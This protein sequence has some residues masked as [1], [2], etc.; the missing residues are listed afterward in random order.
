MEQREYALY[1]RCL[2]WYCIDPDFRALMDESPRRAV[3]KLGYGQSLNGEQAYRA[4]RW[5]VF[6]EPWG[7]APDD[8][9][10]LQAV[11]ARE[12][13]LRS[14][15]MRCHSR[16]GF[17]SEHLYSYEQMTRNRCRMESRLVRRNDYV[18]YFPFCIELSKGCSVQCSF[19]GL[20]AEPHRGDFLYTEENRGLFR[21]VVQAAYRHFGSILG[22]CPLYFATEPF[23]NPDYER[24]MV[25]FRQITGLLPQTTTAIA[26]RDPQRLRRWME[27][28]GPQALQEHAAL[29]IS[30]RS[31]EQFHKIAALYSPEELASVELVANNPQ[32]IH[33]YSA[34]GRAMDAPYGSRTA[35][36]YSICCIS[37]IRVNLVE[38]SVSFLEPEVPSQAYPLGY[39]LRQVRTFRDAGEFALILEEFDRLYFQSRMPR[40][41]PLR[42]NAN[43]TLR[44]EGGTY[45]F[46]GDGC[47]YRIGKN[48]FTQEIVAGIRENQC[49][50]Q[51]ISRFPITA[52]DV[53]R[54]YDAFEALYIRGYIQTENSQP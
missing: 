37:G 10:Y 8:N 2:E 47:G 40:E 35:A 48:Q 3:E 52:G 23:D 26:N 51:I 39:H 30:I 21:S 7:Q 53:Q 12:Q 28:I 43:I 44:E 33:R 29:R 16:E 32:S 13:L 18:F 27:I 46:L 34:S 49:F 31:V 24:F 45:L 25:D 14:H 15:L 41:L 4:I 9:P 19:C 38:R 42:F 20:S 17:A 11:L 22:C 50:S 6:R 1:K 36:H 54:L 5:T